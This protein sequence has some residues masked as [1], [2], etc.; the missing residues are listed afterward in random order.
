MFEDQ[1][2]AETQPLA[3]PR[4]WP[5]S[6]PQAFAV[7]KPSGGCNLSDCNVQFTERTNPLQNGFHNEVLLGE[8][9]AWPS[10]KLNLFQFQRLDSRLNNVSQGA[11]EI[12][13]V[14]F[15]GEMLSDFYLPFWK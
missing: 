4:I 3:I 13:L 11:G 14:L 5:L 2:I 8:G 6:A 7:G 10:T 9:L 12:A 1:L 15:I